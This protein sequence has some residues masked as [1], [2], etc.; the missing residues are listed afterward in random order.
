MARVLSI[1]ADSVS[2]L[3]SKLYLFFFFFVYIGV[4]W[5]W[6]EREGTDQQPGWQTE[7]QVGSRLSVCVGHQAYLYM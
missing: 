1:Q 4:T 5:R 3:L 2:L 6:L 7:R